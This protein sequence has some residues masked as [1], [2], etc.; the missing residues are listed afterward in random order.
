MIRDGQVIVS[1]NTLKTVT[2]CT[3]ATVLRYVHEKQKEEEVAALL[4]GVAFHAAMKVRWGGGT[5][6]QAMA[7][8]RKGYKTWALA[9]VDPDDKYQGRLSWQNLRRVVRFYFR[10]YPLENYPFTVDPQNL[11]V[12]FWIP[13]NKR[14]DIIGRGI[15]DAGPVRHKDTAKLYN[16]DHKSSGGINAW[17]LAKFKMDAQPTMYTWAV[18]ELTP[19]IVSGFYLNVVEFKMLPGM[20]NPNAKCK[21][22]EH[23]GVPYSECQ[24]LHVK[25]ECVML[26]RGPETVKAWKRD[27]IKFARRYQE[28]HETYGDLNH[29]DRVPQEGRF[30]GSCQFCEF[31]DFCLVNRPVNMVDKMLVPRVNDWDESVV[32]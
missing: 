15:I 6:K 23:G 9:N 1:N 11:E 19:E 29:I 2:S 14:G 26:E 24:S 28:I 5:I 31:Q 4:A 27:A 10:R 21:N 17:W 20:N 22:P 8:F 3:T 16:V 13:L 12:P 32:K 18:G 30:N 25:A 7:T